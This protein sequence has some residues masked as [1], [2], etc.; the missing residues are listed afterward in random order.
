MI[1]LDT[2]AW[3]WLIDS[4]ERLGN[5]AAKAIQA[6]RR[7]KAVYISSISVWEIYMLC[8]HGRLRFA[9]EPQVWIA[10]CERIAF[11]KFL[12]VDNEIAR[13]AVQLPSPFHLDPADRLIAAAA[14]FLGAPLASCDARIRTYPHVRS[15]WE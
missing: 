9:V 7:K 11:L 6:A 5:A 2:H 1:V 12:P 4:P 13:L 3:I 8:A 10:R 15:V 14:R